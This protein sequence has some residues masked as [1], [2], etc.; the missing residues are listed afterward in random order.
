VDRRAQLHGAPADALP[1]VHRIIPDRVGRGAPRTEM[2]RVCFWTQ[3]SGKNDDPLMTFQGVARCEFR[4]D[5]ATI[6]GRASG[7]ES[8]HRCPEHR[9]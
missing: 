8:Q 4:C 5:S 7:S 3:R 2:N 1:T 6:P 9:V